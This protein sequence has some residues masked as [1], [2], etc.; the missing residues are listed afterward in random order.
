MW[1]RP[2]V[3]VASG[4]VSDVA[5]IGLILAAVVVLFLWNRLP[6]EIVAIGAA[7]SLAA[8]GILT[9]GETLAGFGDATVIFIAA[10]FVVSEGLDSSGVTTW[11]GQQLVTRAGTS[12]TRLLLLTMLL[13]AL[14]TAVISVNGAVAALLPMVVVIAIRVGMPPSQLMMPLAFAAHAGSLLVLTGSPVNI[15][16]SDVARDIDGTGFGFFEFALVGIPLVVG[17]F[18]LILATGS[19]LLPHR[20]AKTL[21]PNLSEHART[22]MDQYAIHEP[23]IRLRVQPGSPLVGVPVDE[24]E[25]AG[26]PELT[27]IGVRTGE[28]HPRGSDRVVEGDLLVLRG[29]P[30]VALRYAAGHGLDDE[31]PPVAPEAARSMISREFGAV[32]VVIPP[33]SGL[34]GEPAFPGMVTESGDLVI[35]AV[36]RRGEDLGPEETVLASGDVLLLQGTWDALE[37]HLGDPDVRVIEPVDLIRRQAVPLGPRSKQ[38]L[39]ILVGMVVLLATGT[40]PSVVAGLLAAIAMILTGVV[41]LE[42]AYRGINW[43]TVVLVA[44]MLPLSKAIEVTGAADL[45]ADRLV[46]ITGP[47]GP[48]ATVLG[49]ALLTAVLGQLISNMATVLVVYPVALAA[50]AEIGVSHR[51]VLMAL[52]VAAAAAFLTPVATPV[53]LMVMGPGAYRFSEYAKFGLPLLLLFLAVAT[54][55]VPLI[56]PF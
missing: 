17:T 22:L 9:V 24:I 53:N 39:A 3:G 40:V 44:A 5:V 1:P 31:P 6:V 45:V 56:W 8:T 41:R 42:Q 48:Y 28:G 13:V 15:L 29:D 55:L 19:R 30:A 14:F 18:L 27:F 2:Q 21:P 50:A 7:L 12:R 32:E 36:Q 54:F 51:P 23:V 52:T 34:I 20:T 47:A 43:T 26:R 37:E 16:M 49:I 10:L 25:L 46:A 33:R 35:L 11:A 4:A 38:A